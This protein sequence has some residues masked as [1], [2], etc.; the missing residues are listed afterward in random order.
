MILLG[1]YRIRFRSRCLLGYRFTL[2][3]GYLMNV[4]DFFVCAIRCSQVFFHPGTSYFVP[5]RGL[6]PPQ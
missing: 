2:I 4:T 1:G 6:I 5:Y 3:D